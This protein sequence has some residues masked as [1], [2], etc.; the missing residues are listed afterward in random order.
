M[1]GPEVRVSSDGYWE[2]YVRKDITEQERMAIT[3]KYLFFSPNRNLLVDTAMDELRYHGFKT[4]K[5]I[6]TDGRRGT[7]FVLCLYGEDDSRKHELA[8]RHKGTTAL[9]YRYW[10][11]D[12][13]TRR[14][15][16]RKEFDTDE[17]FIDFIEGIHGV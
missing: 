1:P 2:W 6:L 17:E 12:E 7:D 4:A 16:E 9:K 8:A 14:E 13:E 3:G 10:K 11:S 15:A 5:I